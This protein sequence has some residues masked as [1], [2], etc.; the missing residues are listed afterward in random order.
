MPTF[1]KFLKEEKRRQAEELN[2]RIYS[3]NKPLNSASKMKLSSLKK[4]IRKLTGTPTPPKKITSYGGVY[5]NFGPPIT[6]GGNALGNVNQYQSA[7]GYWDPSPQPEDNR[8]ALFYGFNG[9]LSQ[10]YSIIENMSREEISAR[11]MIAGDKIPWKVEAYSEFEKVVAM[12]AHTPNALT[13]IGFEDALITIRVGLQ[14]SKVEDF[15]EAEIDEFD[16]NCE[17]TCKPGSHTCGK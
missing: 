11:M 17:V 13:E 15:E 1:D 6:Q 16:D 5:T 2:Q 9:I 8:L 7:T 14:D 4:Q 10:K 12:F 3:P